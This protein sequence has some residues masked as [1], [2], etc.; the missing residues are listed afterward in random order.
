MRRNAFLLTIATALIAFVIALLPALASE[1]VTPPVDTESIVEIGERVLHQAVVEERAAIHLSE[2]I[3]FGKEAEYAL[4]PGYYI[5]TGERDGW[6]TYVPAD[7]A[8][9]GRVKKAQGAITLQG[10]F[11]YSNDGKTIG[12]ITNFYQAVNAE[13]KGITRTTRDSLSSHELQRSLIYGGM[14][15]G[16]VMLAYREVWR[17]I[18]RPSADVFREYDLTRSK[19][20]E[21]EGARL[22]ILEANGESLRYRVIKA[23][24]PTTPQT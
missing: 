21:V 15:E 20:I 17:N 6:E 13:A 11:H 14:A 5:R 24:D 2:E 23:F 8:E 12:V 9:A 4:T 18:I 10:S 3:T 22:E 16:K 1:R 7:G 19:I